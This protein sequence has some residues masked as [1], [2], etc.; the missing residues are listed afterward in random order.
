[1]TDIVLDEDGSLDRE[2]SDTIWWENIVLGF[3]K[4]IK[5]KKG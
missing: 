1:M 3:I 5:P 2:V 4:T